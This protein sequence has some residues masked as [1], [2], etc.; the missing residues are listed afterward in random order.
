[1]EK[2]IIIN[3]ENLQK[4]KNFFALNSDEDFKKEETLVKGEET[5][6]LENEEEKEEKTETD[7][8]GKD[9]DEKDKDKENLDKL[10]DT[11]KDKKKEKE[12]IDSKFTDLEK[13]LKDELSK[14]FLKIKKEVKNYISKEEFNNLEKSIEDKLSKSF[15]SRFEDLSKNLIEKS[16]EIT[17]L[18]ARLEEVE[19]SPVRPNSTIKGGKYLEKSFDNELDKR[20]EGMTILSI[21]KNKSVIQQILI[22][23]S[24]ID[25]G[26]INDLYKS[27]IMPFEASSTLSKSVINEL[28]KDNIQIIN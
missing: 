10:D 14:D 2:S 8:E 15:E 12:S 26:N 1:M 13:S 3:D 21:S 7:K 18:K 22:E 25:T 23:R 28:E 27:A 6:T 20:K 19:N 17:L 9:D 11:F 16:E 4:A 5:E 24:G